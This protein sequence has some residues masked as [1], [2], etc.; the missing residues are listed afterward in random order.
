MTHGSTTC[1]RDPAHD[2]E[3]FD[4]SD[5]RRAVSTSTAGIDR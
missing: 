3:T 5:G 1:E 4:D 2:R